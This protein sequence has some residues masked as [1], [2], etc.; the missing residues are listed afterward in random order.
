MI[1]MAI[2]NLWKKT[3]DRDGP[4]KYTTIQ[5]EQQMKTYDDVLK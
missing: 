3:Q 5:K 1:L 4:L 2:D